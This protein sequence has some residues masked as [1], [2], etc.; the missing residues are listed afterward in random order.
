MYY[1]QALVS[2]AARARIRNQCYSTTCGPTGKYV[3][4]VSRYP[5]LHSAVL[6]LTRS[7]KHCPR[8]SRR[9]VWPWGQS[10]AAN[11]LSPD[12]RTACE[13]GMADRW[14]V[15]KILRTTQIDTGKNPA[16]IDSVHDRS[17]LDGSSATRGSCA[18]TSASMRNRSCVS[19]RRTQ[20]TITAARAYRARSFAAITSPSSGPQGVIKTIVRSIGLL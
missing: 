11:S 14:R 4:A 20:E 7:G 2:S 13:V 3:I 18:P 12:T 10:F 9:P 8:V 5:K 1:S 16:P 15:F 6:L 19:C 17:H